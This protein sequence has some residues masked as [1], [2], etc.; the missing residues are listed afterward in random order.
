[1]NENSVTKLYEMM[2]ETPCNDYWL[3]LD[4]DEL[5]KFIKTLEQQCF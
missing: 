4:R 5:I 3:K 2:K 1:M